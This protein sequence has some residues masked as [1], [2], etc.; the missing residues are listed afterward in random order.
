MFD[1]LL[2]RWRARRNAQLDAQYGH[3][4]LEER[5]E[6][7][8]L[9]QRLDDPGDLSHLGEDEANRDFDAAEGRPGEDY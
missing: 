7:Q 1:R 5:R 4:T 3:A 2:S 8:E 9:N 6:Q